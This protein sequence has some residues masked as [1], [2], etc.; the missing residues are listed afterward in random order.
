MTG[1]KIKIK[2][3]S[4]T[5][6]FTSNFGPFKGIVDNKGCMRSLFFSHIRSYKILNGLT[7]TR[8]PPGHNAVPGGV[9][10]LM[11]V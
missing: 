8:A 1:K 7:L 11:V 3:T 9:L 5:Q 6:N 4:I 10:K 2:S